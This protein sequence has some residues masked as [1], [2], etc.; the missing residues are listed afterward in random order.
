[1]V[2]GRESLRA[3]R[4][5]YQAE[6]S[7]PVRVAGQLRFTTVEAGAYHTCA[8]TAEGTAYCWGGGSLLGGAATPDL[9]GSAACA[10]TPVAVPGRRFTALAVGRQHTCG[11]DPSGAAYCWGFNFL[12]ETGSSRFSESSASHTRVPGTVAFATIAAGDRYTCA[13]TA[14]GALYCW[15]WLTRGSSPGQTFHIAPVSR[16]CG[17]AHRRFRQQPRSAFSRSLPGSIM[18]VG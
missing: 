3:D 6:T 17:A 11:L 5:G 10:R 2:L 7:A 4:R 9:C 18:L 14:E 12:G 16:R 8:L 13:L 15:E 1:M